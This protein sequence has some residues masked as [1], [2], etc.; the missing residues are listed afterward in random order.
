MIRPMRYPDDLEALNRL[1]EV[2]HPRRAPR[3]ATFW[4][5][6]GVLV[7]DEGEIVA[8]AV[9]SVNLLTRVLNLMDT[10]VSPSARGHGLGAELMQRRLAIGRELDCL[11]A[12]GAVA[13]DNA[14]MRR[15]CASAGLVEIVHVTGLYADET[16]PRDGIVVTAMLGRPA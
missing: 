3:S 16:P 9:Y 7:A 10:A 5:S 11:Q 4:A 2:C 13:P 15:I 6:Q 12:V 14:A 1:T 8:Y